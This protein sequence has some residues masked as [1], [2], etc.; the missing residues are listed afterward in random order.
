MTLIQLIMDLDMNKI[1][2]IFWLYMIRRIFDTSF[3]RI[4]AVLSQLDAYENERVIAYGSHA[5]NPH[6]L[7]YSI[8]RK[9]CKLAIILLYILNII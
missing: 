2:W 7:G 4:G 8:T 3:Y 1:Y 9:N 6:E 5:M